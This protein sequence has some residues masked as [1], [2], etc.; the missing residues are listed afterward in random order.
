MLIS[1]PKANI[2]DDSNFRFLSAGRRVKLS[3]LAVIWTHVTK[4]L[5]MQNFFLNSNAKLFSSV[6]LSYCP[7]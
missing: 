1:P 2:F 3:K 5:P 7:P 4:Y 6:Q